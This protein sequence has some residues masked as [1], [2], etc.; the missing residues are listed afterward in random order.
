MRFLRDHRLE[1]GNFPLQ[2]ERQIG[3]VAENGFQHC[4]A[5]WG[6][7]KIDDGVLQGS[8]IKSFDGLF[9]S[10]NFFRGSLGSGCK[11]RS[12]DCLAGRYLLERGQS[13]VSLDAVSMEE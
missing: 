2:A 4:S 1:K 7:H 5:P 11:R 6:M 10:G 12:S 13:I 3:R 9:P 8:A